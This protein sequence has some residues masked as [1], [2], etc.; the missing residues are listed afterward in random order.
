MVSLHEVTLEL[1]HEYYKGYANDPDIFMDMSNFKEFH[2]DADRIDAY[3]KSKKPAE[4]RKEF[5]IMLDGAPIGEIC[6]KHIKYD[7]KEGE[8]SIHLQNDTVKNKGYGTEAERLL[9]CYAFEELNLDTVLADSVLKNT[10]SQHVLEKV[11]FDFVREEG[12]FKYYQFT[13][14]KY[15]NQDQPSL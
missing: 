7:K 6:L 9:L 14:E 11:G 10:R 1:M 3:Y 15:E 5:F 4:D 13:R 8:L 2:Y 12:I